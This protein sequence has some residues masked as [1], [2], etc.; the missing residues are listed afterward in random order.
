MADV[1]WSPVYL[2][3]AKL[4]YKDPDEPE[5]GLE[6][7]ILDRSEGF[8][9]SDEGFADFLDG[10]IVEALGRR[11]DTG[12]S[13]PCKAYDFVENKK[14]EQDRQLLEQELLMATDLASFEEAGRDLL[15]R[16]AELSG[17]APGVAMLGRI[18]VVDEETDKGAELVALFL[19]PYQEAYRMD[20]DEGLSLSQV[21]GILSKKSAR[22]LLYPMVDE[23]GPRHDRLKIHAR[24]AS[25]PFPGLFSV[26]PPPTTEALLQAE[27]ARAL[28]ARDRKAEERY[29][30]YFEKPPPRRR[31]LFGEDR[32]V[33]IADLLPS[34]DAAAVARESSRTARDLY[35]KEQK[36][37]LVIDGT[38][39]VDA[40]AEGLG[41]S[42][43]LAEKGGERFLVIRGKHFV[44]S[45]PQVCPLDFL[46]VEELD[47]LLDR[48]GEA[49]S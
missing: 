22:S 27:V 23:T 39:R 16:L 30:G 48:M 42:F 49:G 3:V 4:G 12:A 43:F 40:R 37:K 14:G 38:V 31:E 34:T 26:R 5:K 11:T 47:D 46:E 17:I 2:V 20:H 21:P 25:D 10:L 7:E 44:T 19:L 1:D 45:T 6:P 32:M 18:R 15:G 24:P 36:V 9:Q 8:P 13:S 29:S 28:Y 41:D 35:Q 33:K